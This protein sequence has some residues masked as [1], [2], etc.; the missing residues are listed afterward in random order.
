MATLLENE[1][2]ECIDSNI[3]GHVQTTAGHRISWKMQP[4]QKVLSG[5]F[6]QRQA[7][8]WHIPTFKLN[9]SEP[10]AKLME[11]MLRIML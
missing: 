3:D 6:G 4:A 5:S 7:N 11:V 9:S 8:S 2:L 1:L 10:L